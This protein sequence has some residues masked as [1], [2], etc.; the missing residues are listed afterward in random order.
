MKRA[1]RLLTVAG[2]MLGALV[3][4]GT[5]M[6]AYTTPRLE[7]VNPSERL[8]GGGPLTVRVTVSRADD[9]TFRLAI[10]IP[11]G[12]VTSLVPPA[13]MPQIGTLSGRIQVG[14]ISPDAEAPFT[15]R[16]LGDNQPQ[17]YPQGP[18]CIA[19]L[20]TS[21]IDAVYL[22][23]LTAS[24]QTLR[25]P[26]YVSTITTG[27]EAAFA[28]GRMVACLP[29]PHVPPPQGATLGAKLVAANLTFT[30]LFTNPNTAG[31]YRWRAFW[32]PWAPP[33]TPNA[34]GTVETQ[35]VDQ[36][37]VQLSI[38][39]ARWLRGRVT[40]TGS[41]LENR[42]GRPGATI[43][44]YIGRTARGV[45]LRTRVQTRARGVYT[46]RLRWRPR[47]GPIWV[48][49]QVVMPAATQDSCAQRTNPAINCIRTTTSSYTLF[50]NRR[51]RAR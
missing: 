4:S 45:R 25:V 21:T 28:S 19:G 12:Y 13:G 2:A 15:G 1:V 11:Q 43:R 22:L 36:I 44:V 50:N 20:G 30:S 6:A 29:S 51:V 42:R 34:A 46:A 38:N 18:A 47:R 5:A 32:T 33:A 37:P 35:A 39:R 24:G 41:L 17:N 8:G 40:I 31:D 48:R 49:T 9:A 7:I 14:A 16:I 10:Y 26:M 3:F 23:E 27:P